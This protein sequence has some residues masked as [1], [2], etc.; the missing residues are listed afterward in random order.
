MRKLK[1]V[2]T[3]KDMKTQIVVTLKKGDKMNK[4]FWKAFKDRLAEDAGE[5]ALTIFAASTILLW[6]YIFAEIAKHLVLK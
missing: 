6:V 1:G 5:L 2:L 3:F 4:V